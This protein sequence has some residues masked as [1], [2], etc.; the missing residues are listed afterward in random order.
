MFI[1]REV[2]L[3]INAI[4]RRKRR[5][6]ALDISQLLT[7]NI[8]LLEPVA[9]QVEFRQACRHRCPAGPDLFNFPGAFRQTN[10]ARTL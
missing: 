5:S 4:E 8:R 2:I 7:I 10:P 9:D 1:A 6:I 3:I